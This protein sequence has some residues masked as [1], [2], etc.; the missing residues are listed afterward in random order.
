MSNWACKVTESPPSFLLLTPVASPWI[1]LLCRAYQVKAKAKYPLMQECLRELCY[2]EALAQCELRA[3]HLPGVTN[4]L[5]DW[6]SRWPFNPEAG[7]RFLQATRGNPMTRV[8]VA[9]AQ[10]RF[11][12]EW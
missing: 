9:E 1:D 5:P 3:V 8:P 4:R 10:F 12:H 6:L 11:S 2:V 7:R